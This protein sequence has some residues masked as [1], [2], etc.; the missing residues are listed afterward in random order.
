MDPFSGSGV[1]A[2]EALK[3]GRRV[4][5]VDL[6]PIATEILRLTIEYIEPLRLKEAFDRVEQDAKP[7][8]DGLYVTECRKC[9]EDIPVECSIWNRD[10]KK[11]LILKEL[12]YKCTNCGE[13]VEKGG[14]PTKKDLKE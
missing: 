10:E 12:R 9:G 11:N 5:A 8:I 6:N 3:R 13:V 2:L 1:T 4:I 14:K 7:Q